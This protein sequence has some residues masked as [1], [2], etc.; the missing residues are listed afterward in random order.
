VVGLG[1]YR[2]IGTAQK[3][4]RTPAGV[5]KTPPAFAADTLGVLSEIGYSPSEIEALAREGAAPLEPRGALNASP[6]KGKE[7]R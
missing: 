7:I 2:G 6:Q 4:A 5:R 3:L 1:T